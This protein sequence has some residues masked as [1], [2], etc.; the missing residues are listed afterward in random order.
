MKRLHMFVILTVMIT[1]FIFLS[2][3]SDHKNET[4]EHSNALSIYVTVYPLQFLVEEIGADTVEVTTV[5]PPGV[6]AHTYEP[7]SR[8][9]TEIATSDAFFYIGPNMEGFVE[10]AADA[11]ASEGVQLIEIE[12]FEH[13]F[14]HEAQESLTEHDDHE[15]DEH[16]DDEHH[17]H[18]YNPHIWIDPLRMIEMAKIVQNTLSELHPEAKMEYEQNT[19]RLIEQLEQLDQTFIKMANEKENKYMIVP[20]AAYDYWTERYGI[21]QIAVSGFSTTEEPSQKH[22]TEI[23][24]LAQSYDVHYVFYE[25]NTPNKLIDIIQTHIDANVATIHNLSVLTDNDIE[26]EEDYFTLME[27]NIDILDEALR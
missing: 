7:T 14:S 9:M 24:Q 3:C 21:E 8:E 2:G 18:L 11:L 17:H 1:I 26:N 20:H 22:L 15:H 19:E 4:S 10:S 16:H 13:L 6:D 25:Q 23:I 12:Q 5:F 27:K